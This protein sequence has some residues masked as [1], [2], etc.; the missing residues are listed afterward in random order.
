MLKYL[1]NL[2]LSS[3]FHFIKGSISP[4]SIIFILFYYLKANLSALLCFLLSSSSASS[5]A[6]YYYDSS[7]SFFNGIRGRRAKPKNEQMKE[8]SMSVEYPD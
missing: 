7:M 6:L 1:F 8:I 3:I 4:P 5:L 2:I